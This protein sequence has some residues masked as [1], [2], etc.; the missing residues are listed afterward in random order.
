MDSER[1]SRITSSGLILKFRELSLDSPGLLLKLRLLR[2]GLRRD[3]FS[4]SS[5][6]VLRIEKSL[7]FI[8]SFILGILIFFLEL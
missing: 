3:E 8:D 6:V 1:L 2:L 4:L 5:L 7:M